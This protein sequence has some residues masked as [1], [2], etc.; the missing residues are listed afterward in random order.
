MA[1]S[2]GQPGG[3]LSQGNPY[4]ALLAN[5]PNYNNG[6]TM[7]G[8]ASILQQA[9][10]GYMI[11][12]D[13]SQ[14]T[15]ANQALIKGMTPEQLP[16]DTYGP[17]SPGGM[18]GAVGQ[19]GQLQ[20]NPYAGKLAQQLLMQQA[21][22]QQQIAAAKELKMAPSYHEPTPG[23][24]VPYSPEVF[25]QLR[26]LR[27]ITGL[28]DKPSQVKIFEYLNNLPDAQKAVLWNIIRGTKTV[29]TGGGVAVIPPWGM[30]GNGG[31]PP[32]AVPQGMPPQGAPMG[33]APPNMP[34][35]PVQAPGGVTMLPK[36]IPPQDLPS[37]KG[38]QARAAAIGKGLGERA[39][40]QPAAASRVQAQTM[41]LDAL[42]DT[43]DRLLKMPGLDEITGIRS[44]LPIIPGTERANAAAQ[45]DTL[46]SK[47]AQTVLQ[48]YRQMSQTGG[49]VGQVSNFEQQMF[50]N[51]LAALD[52]AQ[53]PEE[54]RNQLG[55]IKQFVAN[56]KKNIA[57]AYTRQYPNEGKGGGPTYP[58]ATPQA[59]DQ[60]AP[61]TP[62]VTATDPKTN[63]KAVWKGDGWYYLDTGEAVK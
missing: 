10:M 60:A 33:N 47:V 61:V 45:F 26:D 21:A 1:M 18:Q 48:M 29:D 63:R 41:P 27:T 51:N 23:K 54:F 62:P 19:L 11:G 22:Q 15:E 58:G 49:A 6:T 14:Q 9:L 28:T 16:A 34:G 50:Q 59:S 4:V 32:G 7:G 40:D 43:V 52:R 3:Y 2:F 53:T 56:S 30:P 55:L 39:I 5:Q 25:A 57:D 46:K 37:V 36:T 44:A 42:S 13:R 24:D 31:T 17:P 12:K 38:D 8:L 20:D 35:A